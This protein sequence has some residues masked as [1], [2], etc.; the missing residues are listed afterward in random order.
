MSPYSLLAAQRRTHSEVKCLSVKPQLRVAVAC[1]VR[2]RAHL[3]SAVLSLVYPWE[4]LASPDQVSAD[5]SASTALYNVVR[6]L[7]LQ[8]S[9]RF[10]RECDLY[11][12]LAPVSG[13]R[14]CALVSSQRCRAPAPALSTAN[15]PE[16]D[17]LNHAAAARTAREAARVAPIQYTLTLGIH[18]QLIVVDA[19]FEPSQSPTLVS[20]IAL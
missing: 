4:S 18:S 6:R 15:L 17:E 3:S 1:T 19:T 13:T 14:L 7:R 5:C 8:Y 16:D 2:L 9:Y 10:W 12:M 11:C 20:R